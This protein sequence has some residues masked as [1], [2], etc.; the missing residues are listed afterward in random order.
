MASEQL[1]TEARSGPR[2]GPLPPVHREGW[3][4][5]AAFLLLMGGWFLAW[6]QLSESFMGPVQPE[7]LVFFVL[8]GL[9]LGQVPAAVSVAAPG[10]APAG[11]PLAAGVPG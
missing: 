5:V 6:G 4:F 11:H 8:L 9:G 2:L 3:K 10:P 7:S 1:E